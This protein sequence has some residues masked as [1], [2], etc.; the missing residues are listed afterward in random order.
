MS[1][2]PDFAATLAEILRT[3]PSGE[4]AAEE[5]PGADDI[6][7]DIAEAVDAG[8]TGMADRRLLRGDIQGAELW[9]SLAT[10]HD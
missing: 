1:K 3:A 4:T 8:C 5:A 9:E 6:A 10:R 2:G 7:A